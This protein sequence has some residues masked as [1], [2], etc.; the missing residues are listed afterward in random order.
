MP[1]VLA[2]PGRCDCGDKEDQSPG[3]VLKKFSADAARSPITWGVLGLSLVGVGV[4]GWR[5]GWL[6]RAAAGL[7]LWSRIDADELDDHPTR[8][9]I[10]VLLGTR[11]GATTQDLAELGSLNAGTLLYHLEILARF[12]L[13][14]SQRVGR[15]RLW[16]LAGAPKPDLQRLAPL[17]VPVRQTLLDMIQG[18]PG[19]TQAD[20]AR[21]TGLSA[22]TIHHHVRILAQAGLV[23][24]RRE[25]ATMR[26]FPP[27]AANGPLGAQSATPRTSS[28]AG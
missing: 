9:R 7:A 10:L 17:A 23:E 13:V 12:G 20:L 2:E 8:S 4:L 27:E 1:I 18:T 11:P 15:E 14:N 22:P 6:P 5:G 19:A 21:L 25:G 28:L 3:G 16:Y 24:L 26:C